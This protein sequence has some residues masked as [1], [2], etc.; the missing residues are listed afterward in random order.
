MSR[1]ARVELYGLLMLDLSR[2]AE[3]DIDAT[4]QHDQLDNQ[5]GVIS[6]DQSTTSN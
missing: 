2:E 6:D 4:A 1:D 3:P 5:N